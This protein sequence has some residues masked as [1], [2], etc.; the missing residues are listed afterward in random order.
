MAVDEMAVVKMS[1]DK[2]AGSR[3][4]INGLVMFQFLNKT[5]LDFFFYKSSRLQVMT[6][7]SVSAF[8]MVCCQFNYMFYDILYFIKYSVH[9]CCIENNAEIFPAHYTWKI[10]VK[11]F[12]MALMMNKFEMINYS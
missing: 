7:T 4:E 9:F 8:T 11:V 10:A 5:F 6:L 12:K 3:S 1:I 2:M